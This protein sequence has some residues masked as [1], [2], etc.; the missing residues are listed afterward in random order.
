[1]TFD[2]TIPPGFPAV[3]TEAF[4]R[5][6]QKTCQVT[7]WQS[8]LYEQTMA[9]LLQ[10][11]RQRGYL[12]AEDNHQWYVRNK[13]GKTELFKATHEQMVLFI[14]SVIENQIEAAK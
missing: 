12:V 2:P 14:L 11:A 6:L 13:Q 1:M 3:I 10:A 4:E 9:L 5:S 7:M 8:V